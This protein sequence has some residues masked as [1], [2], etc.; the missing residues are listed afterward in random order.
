VKA[1][2]VEFIYRKQ[3]HPLVIIVQKGVGKG[4]TREKRVEGRNNL[5][6]TT[7]LIKRSDAQKHENEIK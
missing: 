1:S 2:G 5:V 6:I 7:T 4:Y 3:K